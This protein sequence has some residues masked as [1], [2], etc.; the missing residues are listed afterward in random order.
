MLAG[1]DA[2]LARYPWIDAGRHRHRGRQLRRPAH[3][4]DRHADR[5]LQGRRSPTAGIANL[6]SFNYTALLPRLPGG[7][8][9]R[10]PA[11]GELMDMLW[12]RSP[13]RYV[14][15]VKTPVLILHGENDNDVPIAEAEQWYIALKDV[16]V[17]T[18]MV[19]YPREGHGL[20]EPRHHVDA[21][22]RSIAWYE[23]A[24]RSRRSRPRRRNRQRRRRRSSAALPV[25]VG[26]AGEAAGTARRARSGRPR[27]TRCA[28]RPVLRRT[29]RSGAGA[30]RCAAGA[31]PSAGRCAPC[32]RPS[33][34]PDVHVDLAGPILA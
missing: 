31:A 6:V 1:V 19:R 30:P 29:S 25:Q 22:D 3:Q 34:V 13:L 16:G 5:P 7:G 33:P 8:V 26:R 27:P 15:K 9:R 23:Q 17:E 28:R 14:A 21:L 4:L 32:G 2:A 18:V 24:L 10:L 12:E 20:R 11:R